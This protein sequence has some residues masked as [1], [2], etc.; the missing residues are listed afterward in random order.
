[1]MNKSIGVIG[2]GLGGLTAALRLAKNGFKV[3]L[4]EKNQSLGGK[5]NQ[6]IH[7]G[8]RFDTGPSLLTM[9]FVIDELYLSLIH[10]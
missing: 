10:I 5:M 4:F 7:G 3:S 1:M 6:V 2:G 9:P 8:Y